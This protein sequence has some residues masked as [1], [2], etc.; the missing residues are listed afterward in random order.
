MYIVCAWYTLILHVI[1]T[2]ISYGGPQRVERNVIWQLYNGGVFQLGWNGAGCDDCIINDNDVIHA[3]WT[4]YGSDI[5][6]A[7]NDA[8]IDMSYGGGGATFNNLYIGDLR[9]DT[10]VGRIIGLLFNSGSNNGVSMKNVT[11]E[12]VLIRKNMSWSVE[13]NKPEQF[14][15]IVKT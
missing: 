2:Q 14:I 12:N 9:I 3:E 6:F 1:Y 10:S 8:V 7:A 13:N 4:G 11:I 15:D 5:N